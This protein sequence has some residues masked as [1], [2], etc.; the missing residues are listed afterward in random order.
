MFTHTSQR[1]FA[2]CRL[3]RLV[4]VAVPFFC[5]CACF[6]VEWMYC[7]TRYHN[8]S[9]TSEQ[10]QWFWKVLSEFSQEQRAWFLQFATGTSR[11][12]VEGFKGLIGMRGPQKFSIHKAPMWKFS[13][14]L[15]SVGLSGTLVGRTPVSMNERV[16]N[17]RTGHMF[18]KP[19]GQGAPSSWAL[20]A[21]RGLTL[22]EEHA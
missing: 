2:A 12:P 17:E 3:W 4:G 1:S 10:V 16:T 13:W 22:V 21:K 14:I 11:V 15:L 7:L 18:S 8:Y 19:L 6:F 20:L 9:H 5:N